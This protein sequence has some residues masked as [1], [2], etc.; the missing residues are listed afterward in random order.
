MTIAEKFGI[1]PE[2]VK[3]LLASGLMNCS[4]RKYE[5]MITVYENCVREGL[6]LTQAVSNAAEVG[7]ISDRQFYKILKKFR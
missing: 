6:P 3:E 2:K 1:P 5:E 7:K 4:A